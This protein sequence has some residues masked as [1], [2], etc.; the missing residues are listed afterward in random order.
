MIDT[1][2][3]MLKSFVDYQ[4]KTLGMLFETTKNPFEYGDDYMELMENT[5][6]FH[7]SAIKCHEGYV[8]MIEMFMK[9]IKI[10]NK[11]KNKKNV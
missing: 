9:N 8:E 3:Q 6:N 10:I 5:I 2:N 11:T 7:K 4:Q 1:T